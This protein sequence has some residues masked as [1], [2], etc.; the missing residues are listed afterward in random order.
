[1]SLRFYNVNFLSI[2]LTQTDKYFISALNL[3]AVKPKI[4]M[5]RQH[6]MFLKNYVLW[7]CT[8]RLLLRL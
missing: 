6:T 1:M 2:R 3:F 8:F 7:G 4:L 5:Q